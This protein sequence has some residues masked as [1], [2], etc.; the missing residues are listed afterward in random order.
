[1]PSSRS[2]RARIGQNL[3]SLEARLVL[4]STVVFN[5]VM[6]HPLG[7]APG[8]EYVELHN[9]MAIDMDLSGWSL[10][11]GIDYK[12]PTGTVVAGGGYLVVAADPNALG[13]PG[14]L[15]PFTGALSNSGEA[16]D[17]INNSAR[18]MDSIDYRDAGVWPAGADGSGAST[19]GALRPD[20][21]AVPSGEFVD[22]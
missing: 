5:E 18:V 20:R 16:I 10:A 2:R 17:L 3:E 4:D 6:Y 22:K 11:G 21:T 7:D 8:M 9:Q 13:V 19:A 12:F 15:G 1:M 14:A